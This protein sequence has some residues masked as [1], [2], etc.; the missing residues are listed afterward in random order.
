[1][2]VG[3]ALDAVTGT[4]RLGLVFPDSMNL[5]YAAADSRIGWLLRS[6]S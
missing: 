1:M 4:R 2:E 5:N 6:G 3:Q